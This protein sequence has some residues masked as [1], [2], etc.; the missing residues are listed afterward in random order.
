M[1]TNKRL[2]TSTFYKN[3]VVGS[4]NL[5]TPAHFISSPRPTLRRK[6]CPRTNEEGPNCQETLSRTILFLANRDHGRRKRHVPKDSLPK[7]PKGKH[8]C[9]E[10]A[11]GE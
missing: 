2:V 4:K 1:K 8:K 6:K 7:H 11:M 3:V 10:I 5:V 9:N